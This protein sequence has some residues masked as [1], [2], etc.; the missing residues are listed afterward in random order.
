M[1]PAHKK[2]WLKR[3]WIWLAAVGCLSLLAV[4]CLIVFSAA[5]VF[6]NIPWPALYSNYYQDSDEFY[7]ADPFS[8]STD[9]DSDA[10]GEPNG[11]MVSVFNRAQPDPVADLTEADLK[12]DWFEARVTQKRGMFNPVYLPFQYECRQGV[13][14][15]KQPLTFPCLLSFKFDFVPDNYCSRHPAF[16]Y[17]KDPVWNVQPDQTRKIAA[18]IEDWEATHAVGGTVIQT[19]AGYTGLLRVFDRYGIEIVNQTYDQPVP[20]FTLMGNMVRTWMEYRRQEVSDGLYEELIRPMTSDMECIHLYGRSFDM[21]WRTDQEWKVYDEILQKDPDFAEVRFWYANQKSWATDNHAGL[22]IEKGRALQGH[23]VMP[24]LNEFDHKNCTDQAV[25]ESFRKAL[26]QAEAIC[27]DHHVVLSVK[28]EV[29]AASMTP[30]QLDGMLKAAE[31]YPCS[32]YFLTELGREYRRR[33]MYEK[34]I[35]LFLSAVQS[36]FLKGSGAFDWEWSVLMEDFYMLGYPDEA[37]Y[38]G[39]KTLD[40]C[41]QGRKP[42]VYWVLGQAFQEKKQYSSALQA[43]RYLGQL[44]KDSWGALYASLTVF[45]SGDPVPLQDVNDFPITDKNLLPLK[46]ARQYLAQGQYEAALSALGPPRPLF[47]CDRIHFQTELIRSDI[48]AL[49]GDPQKA[50]LYAVN[51]WA[52][53]PR[54]RQAAWLLEQTADEEDRLEMAH[55]AAAG[56]FICKDDPCWKALYQQYREALQTETPEEMMARFQKIQDH[57]AGLSKEEEFGFWTERLP[58]EMEY[59]CM[60]LLRS[61]RPAERDQILG[62]YLR[63]SRIMKMTSDEQTNHLRLFFIQLLQ[64]VPEAERQSW[65]QRINLP[66]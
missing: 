26:S 1:E 28:L 42:F 3:N 25:L 33:G 49:S 13:P 19:E 18:Y 40:D 24:A 31:K 66:S 52:I 65:I 4:Q 41:D 10:G 36:G 57:L 46:E 20:Y 11:P 60:A 6:K 32:C 27:G 58:F 54:S 43:F 39:M 7:K 61:C 55:Y 64:S 15:E 56:L 14:D 50:R 9:P 34:S 22:Q 51:A 23:L 12:Q 2:T 44:K 35:P 59:L 53:C 30:E 17:R 21:E 37:I 47:L 16:I 5:M 38:C 45:Q 48:Y 29:Q 62:L 63:Y 8:E